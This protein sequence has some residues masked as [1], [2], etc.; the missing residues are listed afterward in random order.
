MAALRSARR[1]D[2]AIGI[3]DWLTSYG[4]T[5][6]LPVPI[7]LA[8]MILAIL[9]RWPFEALGW[10]IPADAASAYVF[11][12]GMVV[13]FVPAFSWLGL[14]V[15]V[16]AVWLVLRLGFGGWLSFALGGATAGM[17]AAVM[18][19]GMAAPVPVSIGVLSALAL[20]R[21]LLWLQP[22]ALVPQT[23]L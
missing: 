10:A 8:M 3:R 20:R 13:I 18:L 21:V 22:A 11:G 17:L 4:A 19:G 5:W 23:T 14:I 9:W 16:P 1:G 12:A 2:R 7:G 15:S 6:L